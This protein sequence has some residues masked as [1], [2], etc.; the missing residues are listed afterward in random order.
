[1]LCIVDFKCLL[2]FYMWVMGMMLIKCLDFEEM[3]FS[4]YFLV[5]GDDFFDIFDDVDECI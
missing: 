5:V 4:F 3:K 1:M 2:D